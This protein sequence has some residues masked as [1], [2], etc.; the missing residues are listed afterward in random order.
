MPHSGAK[1]I[2]RS[3][4]HF[5]LTRAGALFL[6]PAKQLFDDVIAAKA[7]LM[8]EDQMPLISVRIASN[9]E[10][11]ARVIAPWLFYAVLRYMRAHERRATCRAKR[12]RIFKP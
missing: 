5:R 11:D 9:K 1:L 4:R 6:D 12:P 8:M 2:E 7:R 10:L 3:A